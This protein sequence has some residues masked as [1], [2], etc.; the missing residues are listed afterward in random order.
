[1][2]ICC[3]YKITSP[4]GK[5]YIGQTRNF[6]GLVNRYKDGRCKNQRKLY[7]SI[8]KHG[9]DLHTL[10]I[11]EECTVEQLNEKEINYIKLYNTFNTEHGLNCTSGGSNPVMSEETKKLH[12]KN[13]IRRECYKN[14]TTPEVMAENTRRILE[15]NK[16]RIGMKET[17]EHKDK[18]GKGNK[19]KVRTEEYKK[20]L[21]VLKKGKAVAPFSEQH[22]ENLRKVLRENAKN[23]IGT[24]QTPE[25]IQSVI[26]TK[27]EN[28]Q[29]KQHKIQSILFRQSYFNFVFN[30]K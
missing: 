26:K 3:I 29:L 30:K 4:T 17:Q 25:H 24:K 12:S 15:E 9:F 11:I 6:K 8:L 1:M 18:I 14:I 20:H 19:G 23:R 10:E 7:Y 28:K 2:K 13:A 22:L 16:K 5:I 27:K 21:S